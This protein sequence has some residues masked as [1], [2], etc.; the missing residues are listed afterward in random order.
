MSGRQRV[1]IEDWLPAAAIGVECMREENNPVAK[2]PHKYL[3]VWWARRPLTVSRAAILGSLLPIDFNRETFERLLGFGRSGQELVFVQKMHDS[4]EPGTTIDIGFDCKRAFK[5]GFFEKDLIQ[6]KDAVNKQW[7]SDVVVMDPMAGGGSI[8]LEAVRMGFKAIAN[9]L[10]PVACTVL[11]STIEYP[12]LIDDSFPPLV[13]KWG[14]ILEDRLTVKVEKYFRERSPYAVKDFIYARTVPCPDTGKPTPLVPSWYLLNPKSGKTIAAIPIIDEKN[15]TWY[16]EIRE[17][18]NGAGQIKNVSPSTY[19]RGKGISLYTGR[20]I[21]GDYIKAMA[22]AGNMKNQL[23]AIAVKTE[24]GLEFFPPDKGD[25]DVLVSAENDYKKI[26]RQWETNNIIP[27]ESFP[28]NASDKRP[29]LYGMSKWSNLFAPRQLLV[30]GT[31][32]DELN[33]LHSDICKAEGNDIGEKIIHL[34]SFSID[35][36]INYNSILASWKSGQGGMRST[37]DRHDYSFKPT[38]AEIAPIKSGE[39]FKWAIKNTLKAFKEISE[40]HTVND[41]KLPTI[42]LGSATHLPQIIDKSITTVVVDPPYADNVQYS[43]MADFFYVWLKRTQGHRR[44]EWFSTYLC[45]H[46]EE[47]VVNISRHRD[48]GEKTTKEAR[49]DAYVFY[50]KLMA[51]TFAESKRIL[52]DDG[53]LTVMFTHKKQE[54]W[55]GLFQSL[56]DAGFTIT[57]TWPIKTE[58]EH[59][60]HQAKKNAAQSTVILV[61]R[62]R[63][64]NAGKGYYD[65]SMKEEI[66]NT[67]ASSA[68]RLQGEGLNAVDQMVGS[69]GPAMEVF[70][71]YD[72]VV[73]DTG[74]PVNVGQAIDE[75]ADAVSEWRINQLAERGLDGVEPEG[76]FYLLCWDVL[77]AQEFRFNEAK[78]LGHAVGMDVNQLITA[79]L[80]TKKSD[81]IIMQTA[82]ERRRERPLEPDEVVE[83]LFGDEIKTKRRSKK[84]VLKVHPNDPEFRTALDACH[85]L[86]LR[87]EEGGL[88]S[89][90]SLARQQNWTVDSAVSKL[91]EALVKAAPIAVRFDK[92]SKSAGHRFPEFRAWHVMLKE[93]FDIIPEEWKEEFNPTQGALFE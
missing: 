17:V 76:Q 48:N 89:A 84:D 86:A 38:W 26:K 42:T 81:K 28:I 85:A 74:E 68:E 90:K 52:R 14:R 35:K 58:S 71:R 91:M 4:K 65:S 34:L 67:A 62:K 5:N 50:N 56:I 53:V 13:K 77:G 8:P 21:D 33:N 16:S 63:M 87:Y 43:E 10:N 60:L 46:D 1:L 2:P 7:D 75:A 64:P 37:F 32:V 23:Y 82:K 78:L 24:K 25:L 88:G 92:G 3:H 55:E 45:D 22:Q 72:E 11:E 19:N 79:G 47:A 73:T 66:R 49:E 41:I 54:A 59:S 40:L 69:F 27:M 20:P 12:F 9:E 51:E 93:I 44:P 31:L 70:S 61:A 83:T 57:A 30:I 39:G 15:G 18:G 80:V 36:L 6:L 29:I